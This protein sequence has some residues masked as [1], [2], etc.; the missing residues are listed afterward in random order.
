MLEIENLKKHLNWVQ[1]GAG[2]QTY[3][4]N[5]LSVLCL[6]ISGKELSPGDVAAIL[7][8]V[9]ESYPTVLRQQRD[10]TWQKAETTDLAASKVP[11]M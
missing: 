9:I 11:C 1:G 3:D 6:S 2:Y 4:S 8:N 10:G 7:P 5:G